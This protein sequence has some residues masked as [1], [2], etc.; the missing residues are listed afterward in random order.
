MSNRQK[1]FTA[2]VLKVLIAACI[3]SVF[4]GKLLDQPIT[5]VQQVI[6]SI[7][8]M[9]QFTIGLIIQR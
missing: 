2:D 3:A 8:I 7:S 9:L 1:D 6:I 5:A 4:A